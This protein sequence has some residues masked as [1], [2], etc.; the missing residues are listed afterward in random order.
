MTKDNKERMPRHYSKALQIWAFIYRDWR[1]TRRNWS[2][3]LVFAFYALVNSVSV[4]LI[5]VATHNTRLTLMLTLGS[6]LWSYLSVLFSEIA[7]SIAFERWE[8]TIEYTFMAPV[9]RLI[10]LIGVSCYALTY[11][12][13]R[14]CI[15]LSG[16]LIFV[17]LNLRG[18]NIVG[19]AVVLVI[20]SIAFVGV[21]L[22]AAI[23]P[24]L[25]PERGA[26]ATN[27]LQGIM[28]LI[29]GVYYPVSILP[30]WLQPLSQIS[31][32]T[33]VLSASRKLMGL[34][35]EVQGSSLIGAPLSSVMPEL[36][37]LSIEGMLLVPLGLW[38]FGRVEKW[39]KATGRLKRTG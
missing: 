6:L 30:R 1:L 15:V 20:G 28:L 32:A 33:Y 37:R 16:L 24:I 31:P 36:L 26:E 39:A 18:I 27:I 8:G 4:V 9:S 29:S 23:L 35:G 3:G 10:H 22:I 34:D 11:S 5:G 12:V 2:W 14:T 38:A 25:N 7:T 17:K 13:A 21:G 19:I